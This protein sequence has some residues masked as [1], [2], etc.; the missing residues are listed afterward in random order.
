MHKSWLFVLMLMLVGCDG[1]SEHVEIED[2][3]AFRKSLVE[4]AL[5]D[6]TRRAGD[7]YVEQYSQ[8]PD[9]TMTKS[10][11]FYRIIKEGSGR[12]PE[13]DDIVEVVYEG[14]LV[15]GD[16]FDATDTDTTAKFPLNQVIKGWREGLN[17]MSEGARWELVIPPELAYGARSPTPSIPPNST[18]IFDV[19]LI[20]IVEPG[21]EEQ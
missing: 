5:N 2:K 20:S 15:S 19:T 4:K 8:R 10:G 7:A 9:V 18:L 3:E 11:L 21:S 6:E 1:S 12:Q 17:N 14:R 13:L 16:L